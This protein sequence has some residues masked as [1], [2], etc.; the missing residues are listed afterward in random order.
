M[1]LR[2]RDL[3]AGTIE[4][5]RTLI[6]EHGY[7]WWGWWNKPDEKIPRAT[8]AAFREVIGRAGFV[9]IFLIDSGRAKLYKA[10]LVD[11]DE[12]KT[13]DL[14]ECSEPKKTPGYYSTAKYKAWFKLT[15]INDAS[16]T[17]IRNW[18]YEEITE[19]LDDP[20]ADRFR[21]KRVF[22]IQEMLNRRH[23]TIYFIK[24]YN[25]KTDQD[26]RLEFLP[27]ISRANFI[28][29]PIVT[30]SDYILHIS[31]LHFGTGYHRFALEA[32][33]NRKKLSTLIID[34]L[35][36]EY[37]DVAPAAVVVSGDLTWHGEEDEFKMVYDSLK[38]L[39]SVFKLDPHRFVIIPGNHD[40]QWSDQNGGTFDREKPVTR[41]S[42]E[43]EK[44]YRTFY[45]NFFGIA[46]N[47]YLSLGRRYLLS[48][49]SAIDIVGLNSCRL[50]QKPFAG[51]GYVSLEQVQ[52]AATEMGWNKGKK[53]DSMVRMLTLHHHVMPVTSKE[54]LEYGRLY[55]LT[56]DAGQLTYEALNFG[57]DL[58]IHGHMHQPFSAALSRAAKGADFSKRTL[59]VHGAGSAGVKKDLT[60]DVGKNSFSVYNFDK[61][62]VT[63]RIRSLS[64]SYEGFGKDWESRFGINPDGGFRSV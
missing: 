16:P 12:S 32:E 28:R 64:E 18:S 46:A 3:V 29:S 6:K 56:L 47:S 40:I 34:D 1:V 59:G 23:R 37:G 9:E 11:I 58:V 10:R 27:P 45:K 38:E 53:P 5:H 8:F 15:E 52:D 25:E 41:A 55:S 39:E 19:F 22:D 63:I 54:E 20:S 13:E 49:Y 42:E 17:E 60:G 43:A 26:Y 2:F 61:D 24:P 51:Y 14:K 35:R 50:E 31:D 48:N 44:N 7:A 57:V 36:R 33:P 21:D 62:G 30:N 4:S